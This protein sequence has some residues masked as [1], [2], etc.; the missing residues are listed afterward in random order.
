M[1]EHAVDI[2]HIVVEPAFVFKKGNEVLGTLNATYDFTELD[3]SLHKTAFGCVHSTMTVY[4]NTD[5]LTL[6]EQKML[7]D[8]K[9]KQENSWLKR[10][11][12]RRIN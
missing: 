12:K 1:S 6:E 4:I 8:Y 2:K 11:F 5:P 10:L 9:Y 7:D 3:P